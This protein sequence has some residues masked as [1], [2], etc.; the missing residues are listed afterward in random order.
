MAVALAAAVG[1]CR[2]S[3][4]DV[5]A[6]TALCD[7]VIFPP[8]QSGSHLIGD[9]DPP[10]PYSSTP[11]TS[12]WHLSGAPPQ[13]VYDRP[14]P[15]PAQ[16]AALEAGRVVVTHNGLPASERARLEGAADL[17]DVT[18]TPYDAIAPGEV[19]FASWGAMQRCDGVDLDALEAYVDAYATPTDAHEHTP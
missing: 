4:P 10:V 12:G 13:G 1:G 19:V 2:S 14:L 15:A 18:V 17:G 5:P 11:P 16:V 9:A 6:A 3:T 8:V 7:E